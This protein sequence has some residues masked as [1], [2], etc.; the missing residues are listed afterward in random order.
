M[1]AALAALVLVLGCGRRDHTVIDE[2]PA[3]AGPDAPLIGSG[4]LLSDQ[5]LGCTYAAECCSLFCDDAICA[6]GGLCTPA[7]MPC[8][9]FR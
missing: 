6:S 4:C 5:G 2:P 9:V 1:R 8:R 7:N 3:D